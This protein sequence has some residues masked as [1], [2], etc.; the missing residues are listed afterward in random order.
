MLNI[1]HKDWF[2]ITRFIATM[3]YLLPGPDIYHD[4]NGFT[5][6]GGWFR[7]NNYE[8]MTPVKKHDKVSAKMF[9][10]HKIRLLVAQL[11]WYTSITEGVITAAKT[12]R[13]V[14]LGETLDNFLLNYNLPWQVMKTI[15]DNI[16]PPCQ[17]ILKF[18]MIIMGV[19]D[20]PGKLWIFCGCLPNLTK[21]KLT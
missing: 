4:L 6:S 8:S 3:K 13:T 10:H 14:C 9:E 19:F 1:T 7:L 17:L 15:H 11:Y 20:V 16:E 18:S 5:M 21:P 2:L 12:F